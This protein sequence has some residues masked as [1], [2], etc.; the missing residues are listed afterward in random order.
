[1]SPIECGEYNECDREAPYGE[2][3]TRNWVEEQQ[4]KKFGIFYQHF[5]V[6]CMYS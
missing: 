3:M 6:S 5:S 1:M 2:A 4:G